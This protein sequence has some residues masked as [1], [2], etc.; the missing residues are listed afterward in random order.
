[1]A[2]K[3]S[4]HFSVVVERATSREELI[5]KARRIEDL[6]YTMCLIPDHFY[7]DID[8][9]VALMAVADSTSLR[10][11][12]HVFCN[13]FRN[14]AV[15]AKQVATLDMLSEGRFQLGLGCGYDQNDYSQT[16]IPFD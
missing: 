10:I 12:S 6:G 2:S 7:F 14:P 4:F 16:G 8:P 15:L 3:H 13:D 9:A 1:M 11:G 5:A